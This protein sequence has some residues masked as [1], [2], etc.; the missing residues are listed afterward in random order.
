V[1]GLTER[2]VP[3]RVVT[4]TVAETPGRIRKRLA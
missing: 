3:V 4:P 2:K 1:F